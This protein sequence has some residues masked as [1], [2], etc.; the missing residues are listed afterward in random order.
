M[1]HCLLCGKKGFFLKVTQNGLCKPCDREV[2]SETE[3]MRDIIN[4]CRR[5]VESSKEQLSVRLSCYDKLMDAFNH[6]LEF[7]KRGIPITPKP[8][9]F[10]SYFAGK[11]DQLDSFCSEPTEKPDQKT[12]D[13]KAL[14]EAEAI[15]SL[16][17]LCNELTI[18][19]PD[20]PPLSQS[21]IDEIR[22]KMDKTISE[23]EK[24]F[25]ESNSK[26]LEYFLGVSILL[27]TEWFIRGD[28]RKKYLQRAVE[29]VEK[30]EECNTANVQDEDYESRFTL[31]NGSKGK[32]AFTAWKTG[33]NLDIKE[34]I[35]QDIEKFTSYLE[36][37]FN[38]TEDYR[39]IFCHYVDAYRSL[40]NYEKAIKLG[41]E[42]HH[43]A[44]NTKK[45]GDTL[46]LWNTSSLS[47]LETRAWSIVHRYYM[48]LPT[49][50]MTTVAKSYR[51]MAKDCK[52]SGE[53]ERAISLFKKLVN[54]G[55]A[56]DNDKKL[57]AKLQALEKNQ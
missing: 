20:K 1:A 10:I 22:S 36:P 3:D 8:S 19:T 33:F 7:E 23:I 25:S 41:L 42:L 11:R 46:R 4:S 6:L 43:R 9:E 14:S 29:H 35:R 37:I 5:V 26:E 54:T 50:P 27:Y 2:V 12:T 48:S 31:F 34:E 45:F 53:T 56:T 28:E 47:G 40:G 24:Q 39:P 13:K 52:K 30:T 55:L 15:E 21:I 49:A 32:D 57:L 17:K 44:E 38:N 16:E 51:R 18:V